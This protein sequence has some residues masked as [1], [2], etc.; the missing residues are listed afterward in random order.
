MVTAGAARLSAL[1]PL[2]RERLGK[3]IVK[4]TQS[5]WLTAK[6]GQSWLSEFNTWVDLFSKTKTSRC[7]VHLLSFSPVISILSI[8]NTHPDWIR[9]QPYLW[10]PPSLKNR[11]TCIKVRTWIEHVQDRLHASILVIHFH[12]KFHII[13]FQVSINEACNLVEEP[14]DQDKSSDVQ[15]SHEREENPTE[16]YQSIKRRSVNWIQCQSIDGINV[17]QFN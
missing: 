11:K 17:N 5:I 8:F 10:H 1:S 9:N 13:V 2:S 6:Y 16:S 7:V 3:K 12:Y 4:T 14:I 15:S